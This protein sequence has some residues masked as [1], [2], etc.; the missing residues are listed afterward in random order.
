MSPSSGS[1]LKMEVADSSFL[2][3]CNF[4]CFCRDCAH[5]NGTQTFYLLFTHYFTGLPP[6]YA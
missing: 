2:G 5:D 1:T 6:L 3:L 4:V